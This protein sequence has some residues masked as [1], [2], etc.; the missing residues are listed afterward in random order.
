MDDYYYKKYK[1]YKNL[2]KNQTAG[3][4]IMGFGNQDNDKDKDKDNY[5]QFTKG[6]RVEIHGIQAEAHQYL[7]GM[8]GEIVE[9]CQADINEG[10]CLIKIEGETDPKMIRPRNLKITETVK[11]DDKHKGKGK[12]KDKGKDKHKDKAKGH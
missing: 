1:K 3:L 6:T 7:N 4:K 12:G 2:Y 5:S 8:T 11:G 10:R 9:V